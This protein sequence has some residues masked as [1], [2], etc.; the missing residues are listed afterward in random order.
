MTRNDV[1]M[2]LLPKTME[3]ADLRETKRPIYHS[4]GTDESYPKMYFSLNLSHY[5]KSYGHLRK[6][7]AFSTMP[8][9]QIWP[10]NVTQEANF[11]KKVYFF[12]IL[13]LI[14]GKAAKCIVEKLST[15]EVI[16]LKPHGGGKHLPPPPPPQ[17]F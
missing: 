16:S 4:K 6:I 2:T 7:S 17:C 12:L 9:L 10:C 13:H 11:G 14:L 3:N 15:S 8:A 1:I 5:V